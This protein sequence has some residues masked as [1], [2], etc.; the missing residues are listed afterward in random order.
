[1]LLEK[2]CHMKSSINVRDQA[3]NRPPA[4]CWSRT[5]FYPISIMPKIFIKNSGNLKHPKNKKNINN[6]KVSHLVSCRVIP[7][8][9]T[10]KG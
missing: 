1:M 5:L 7:R 6:T 4:K 8:P 9:A 3:L 2:L 10:M